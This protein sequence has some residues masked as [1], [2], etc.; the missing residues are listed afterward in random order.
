MGTSGRREVEKF[1]LLLEFDS[2]EWV[3]FDC[4]KERLNPQQMI[5]R[6][7]DTL[8]VSLDDVDLR[9]FRE[10]VAF[11][12][13]DLDQEEF[14]EKSTGIVHALAAIAG[15]AEL[16][17]ITVTTKGSLS[18]DELSTSSVTSSVQFLNSVFSESVSE[19]EDTFECS[20][21]EIAPRFKVSSP[22]GLGVETRIFLNPNLEDN[23]CELSLHS[24]YV[25]GEKPFCYEEIMDAEIVRFGKM[26]DK[27][28]SL[29]VCQ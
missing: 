4:I 15:E 9:G 7:D 27:L 5:Y 1:E 20:I 3:S 28:L 13:E 10:V 25:F 18:M 22:D 24:Q 6:G 21:T 19:I 26:Y 29:E 16:I 11:E 8:L 14:R 2:P 12:S 23:R 17:S